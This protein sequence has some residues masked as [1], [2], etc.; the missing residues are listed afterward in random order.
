MRVALVRYAS[1]DLPSETV[2]SGCAIRKR[3]PAN[4]QGYSAER[5]LGLEHCPWMACL[6]SHLQRHHA[7]FR[8]SGLR[9]LHMLLLNCSSRPAAIR[10]LPSCRCDWEICAAF[11]R[12]QSQPWVF[13]QHTQ[14]GLHPAYTPLQHLHFGSACLKSVMLASNDKER[15]VSLALRTLLRTFVRIIVHLYSNSIHYVAVT[16]HFVTQLRR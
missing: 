4:G 7:A 16:Q 9:H 15:A 6:D 14:R 5:P 2:Q 1:A 12:L 11:T 3:L 13:L 10:L 8:P